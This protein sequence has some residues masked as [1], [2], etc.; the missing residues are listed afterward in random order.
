M[1]S[2]THQDAEFAYVHH[3]LFVTNCPVRIESRHDEILALTN[4]RTLL[5]N[6]EVTTTI[7]LRFD[8]R[9]TAVRLRSLQSQ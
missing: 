8:G 2:A 3:I 6:A 4:R 5:N 7:R 1:K 9:S